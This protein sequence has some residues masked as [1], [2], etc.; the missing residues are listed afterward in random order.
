MVYKEQK[1]SAMEI[2]FHER[3]EEMQLI[4]MRAI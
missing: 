3:E 4:L 2:K 1:S